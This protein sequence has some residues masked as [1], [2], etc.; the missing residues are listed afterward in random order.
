MHCDVDLTDM[1]PGQSH[2]T[3]LDPMARI[4]VLAMCALRP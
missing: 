3:P 2:D 4:Q 1:T